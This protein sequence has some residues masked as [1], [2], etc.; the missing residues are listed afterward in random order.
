MKDVTKPAIT[1]GGPLSLAAEA[2]TTLSEAIAT[3]I[4]KCPDGVVRSYGAAGTLRQ[5]TYRGL[6]QRAG[7][8]AAELAS[9]GVPPGRPVVLLL[10]DVADFAA[11]FWACVRGGFIA[12][13][14]NGAAQDTL[15]NSENTTFRDVLRKL[16]AATI[17]TDA[18]FESLARSF[19]R[20]AGVDVIALDEG[21]RGSSSACADGPPADPTWLIATS[22]S[23]GLLKLAALSQQ[24]LLHR[25]F[26]SHMPANT[27]LDYLATFPIDSIATT[28]LLFPRFRS[29]LQI[30]GSLL[31]SAPTSLLD[32][33][34]QFGIGSLSL[35]NSSAK[36][37]LSAAARNGGRWDLSSLRQVALGGEPVVPELMRKLSDFLVLQ[38]ARGDIIRA[39]YGST[40]TGALVKGA[41]PTLPE[42]DDAG[43]ARLGSCPPGTSL[44]IVGDDGALLAEGE[45]G[46]V[47]VSTPLRI[48]SCYWGEPQATRDSFTPDGWWRTGDTGHLQDGQLTLKGRRKEII[49]V[50]GR[51]F[52]LAA[53]DGELQRV[54]PLD[55][56]AWSCAV[57]WP[58]ED[59]ER[60]AVV[61]VASQSG[62][63][64]SR[65]LADQVRHTVA[66]RFGIRPS[67]VLAASAELISRTAGGK[68]RRSALVSLVRSG[69]FGPYADI[70]PSKTAAPESPEAAEQALAA[71]WC[72]V[73]GVSGAPDST[74]T[75]FDLGGDSLRAVILQAAIEER[76][77]ITIA[78][79]DFFV[80][81]TFATLLRL[82]ANRPGHVPAEPLLSRP[83]AVAELERTFAA[84]VTP[85]Y[86]LATAY[87]WANACHELLAA[88]RLPILEYAVRHLTTVYPDIEY[89]ATIAAW[90]D[91]IPR[92]DGPA[93]PFS[94]DVD[95]E[96]QIVRREG[97]ENVLFCFCGAQGT[98]GV[99][100][101]LAHEWLGRMPV[102]LVYIKDV[103]D[104]WGGG[105]YPTLA[106]DHVRSAQALLQIARTLGAR[107]IFTLGVSLGGYPALHYGRKLGAE[108]VLNLGGATDLS[109]EFDATEALSTYPTLLQQSPDYAVG[110]R[111]V[112]AA[113]ECRPRVLLVFGDGH[114]IDRR[115]A[116]RMAG[117][118]GVELIAVD[119]C[120]QHNVSETLMRR[121]EYAGILHRLL[122]LRAI[123]A[124][125]A[126]PPA[127]RPLIVR[128][129]W[130][131]VKNLTRR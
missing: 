48:F 65:Q 62:A 68:L 35:T 93:I 47:Q 24:A 26:P 109:P 31:A 59:A 27:G 9:R 83:Q 21:F 7:S 106:A 88:G 75:F 1:D 124:E 90:F 12:V 40:E 100:L 96:V 34:E 54:L 53:I 39:G 11:S 125:V 15:R 69:T 87:Q 81:P 115:Q 25:Q 85:D 97:C 101:N 73:L 22:G 37:V 127:Q 58:G 82:V 107:R 99:P 4:A 131:R 57:H 46:D 117:L 95:A 43:A 105:G 102:S 8:I 70:S 80:D 38:G 51:K 49:I 128:T 36:L 18:R 89:L 66:R 17:L 5:D 114:A 123:E 23:T 33:V 84:G 72:E 64:A 30:P 16:K 74:V 28:L 6:W 110:L 41:D 44:R 13:P 126:K 104:I 42:N 108:G 111:A 67:P 10:D 130:D 61:L 113:S 92:D 78:A 91:A 71:I 3:R 19:E 2:Q 63:D 129:P 120:A 60:L 56:R 32:A 29:W 50:H 94:D 77:A 119:R 79:D 112:Y 55:T 20:E 76:F 103:R 116:E 45:D 122:S 14:L 86:A 98:L 52:S 121:K 118:P